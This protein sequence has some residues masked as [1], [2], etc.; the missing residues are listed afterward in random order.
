[1][2][3]SQSCTQDQL[4]TIAQQPVNDAITGQ[5]NTVRSQLV[6]TYNPT[7]C[8]NSQGY[9]Y[10]PNIQSSKVL[11]P[12][13]QSNGQASCPL[14]T[15]FNYSGAS[16][17]SVTCPPYMGYQGQ[18]VISPQGTRGVQTSCSYY[19]PFQGNVIQ[20]NAYINSLTCDSV[21]N[22]QTVIQ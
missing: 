21:S 8:P 2:S 19:I 15:L 17:I 12:P 22:S 3:L 18:P 11:T 6:C 20:Y 14:G 1:M 7:Y 16:K 5:R 9:C 13:S 10:L 4:G